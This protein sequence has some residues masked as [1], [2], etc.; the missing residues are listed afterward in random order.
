MKSSRRHKSF[1]LREDA[2]KQ[3][4]AMVRVISLATRE[5]ATIG[6]CPACFNLK[7]RREVLLARLLKMGY[8]VVHPSDRL[9]GIYRPGR[10]HAPGCRSGCLG[11]DDWE[12]F[13][14]ALGRSKKR[15]G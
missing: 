1:S 8:E 13:A 15:P 10:G 12:E 14:R 9:D 4:R 6:V 3:G 5:P 11:G 7:K 2:V